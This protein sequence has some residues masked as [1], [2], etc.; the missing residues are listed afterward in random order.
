[1]IRVLVLFEK[2]NFLLVRL[3]VAVVMMLVGR[4]DVNSGVSQ[5]TRVTSLERGALLMVPWLESF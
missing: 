4:C 1:M 2:D 5:F 3:R